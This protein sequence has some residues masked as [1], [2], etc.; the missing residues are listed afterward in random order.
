M[1]AVSD[2]RDIVRRVVAE[3]GSYKASYGEIGTEVIMDDERGHYE[4]MHIGWLGPR[5]IHGA[6]IHIDI[7]GDKIWIQ[8][9]GTSPGVAQDLLEAG[10]PAGAIVLGFHPPEARRHTGFAVT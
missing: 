7:I 3:Y 4:V 6:V 1:V 5:R 8:H 9:D 2:Y 10:I